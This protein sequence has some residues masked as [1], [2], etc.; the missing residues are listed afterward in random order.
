MPNTSH[1]DYVD[2]RHEIERFTN[3]VSVQTHSDHVHL[4]FTVD[5]PRPGQK[6]GEQR[7]LEHE[8]VARIVMPEDL[9]RRLAQ[10][11]VLSGSQPMESAKARN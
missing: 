9:F 6:T 1:A 3:N 8:I 10:F 7:I 11:G 2:P 4:T 5:R